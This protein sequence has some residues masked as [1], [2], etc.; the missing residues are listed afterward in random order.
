MNHGELLIQAAKLLYGE[1]WIPALSR[2]IG[3]SERTL[4]AITEGR[5]DATGHPMV[6]ETLCL[7]H[8]RQ[9]EISKFLLKVA[10]PKARKPLGLVNAR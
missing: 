10:P 2:D 1:R 7:L 5:F 9:Q 8:K 4:R 6:R 3:V